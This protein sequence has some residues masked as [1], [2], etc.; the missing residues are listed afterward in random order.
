VLACCRPA[1]PTEK[2]NAAQAEHDRLGGAGQSPGG[3]GP[4]A[5]DGAVHTGRSGMEPAPARYNSE[6]VGSLG[7][8]AQLVICISLPRHRV[9][10]NPLNRVMLRNK[11]LDNFRF[12][13]GPKNIDPPA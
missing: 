3:L 11:T 12:A 8:L 5:K 7:R 4:G 2:H 6:L 9:L 10:S 13:I 1:A